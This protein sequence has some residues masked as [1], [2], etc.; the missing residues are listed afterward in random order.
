MISTTGN[1]CDLSI[2]PPTTP[3][4]SVLP[5]SR[6]LTDQKT[7]T[8]TQVS[9]Q[10]NLAEI[11]AIAKTNAYIKGMNKVS[12]FQ[13]VGFELECNGIAMVKN[14][15]SIKPKLCPDNLYW[16]YPGSHKTQAY[17]DELPDEDLLKGQILA[18]TEQTAAGAPLIALTA[19][20]MKL[21]HLER[22]YCPEL[23]TAPLTR[24]EFAQL[25]IQTSLDHIRRVFINHLTQPRAYPLSEVIAIC[26]NTRPP[27]AMALIIEDQVP[28]NPY[29]HHPVGRPVDYSFY[30]DPLA[31]TRWQTQANI[32][33]PFKNIKNLHFVMAQE[34]QL[35]KTIEAICSDRMFKKLFIEPLQKNPLTDAWLWHF[36][37][38]AMSFGAHLGPVDAKDSWAELPKLRLLN[39]RYSHH[40]LIMEV[41]DEEGVDILS[42]T[43]LNDVGKK[44]GFIN[45]IR[46]TVN[47]QHAR[48]YKKED[49]QQNPGFNYW[50]HDY[51]DDLTDL[52][53]LRKKHGKSTVY[54]TNTN[55]PFILVDD[56]PHYLLFKLSNSLLYLSKNYY[57]SVLPIYTNDNGEPCT[58]LERRYTPNTTYSV[59]YEEH[60]PFT[61]QSNWHSKPTEEEQRHLS[62]YWA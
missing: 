52:C 40:Q 10:L 30:S 15:R 19:E 38:L 39:V 57:C 4:R 7:C 50:L 5:K 47:D 35:K 20:L 9:K 31:A 16:Y 14:T 1:A 34:D 45:L 3:D 49:T 33:I 54:N 13:R 58:V 23:I 42:R 8:A 55:K 43:I 28:Q 59:T 6:E 26:N 27:D 29:D 22:I 61:N 56:S 44:T 32:A 46:Q 41:L 18:R 2:N 37:Y 48:E 60:Y 11:T 62:L 25:H 24:Q 53:E 12:D 36:L 17:Y 51:L 21:S